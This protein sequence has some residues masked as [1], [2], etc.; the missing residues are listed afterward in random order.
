[1]TQLVSDCPRCGASRVAFDVKAFHQIGVRYN[2]QHIVEA[3][4]ICR[5]CSKSTVFV[6]AQENPESWEKFHKQLNSLVSVNTVAKIGGYVSIKDEAGI[7]PPEHLPQAIKSAFE[8]GAICHAVSCPNA[9]A[10]M[11]RL[12]L[13]IATKELLPTEENAEPKQHIRNRLGPRIKWLLDNDKLPADLIELSE[14][15]RED[16]NDGAHEGTLSV[17]DVLDLIDFTIALLERLYTQPAKIKLA[18]GRRAQRR[19]S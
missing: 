12:C 4:A 8:E 16:G 5:H 7:S 9:A 14:T 18:E 2:W 15:V 3:F 11:F 13:D 1:M 6:L 10:T 19:G 17:P